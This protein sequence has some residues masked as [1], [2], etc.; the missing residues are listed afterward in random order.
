MKS[1]AFSNG[2]TFLY[3]VIW[4]LFLICLF[5][6]PLHAQMVLEKEAVSVL[7]L[8]VSFSPDDDVS[9]TGNGTFLAE[10]ELDQCGDYV[11]DPPPHNKAYFDAHLRA[12][13]NY[14]RSVSRGKFGI[15]LDSSVIL[16]EEASSS[17]VLNETMSS[18]YPYDDD[19]AQQQGLARLFEKSLE[20]SYAED[21]LNFDEFDIIIVFHA[22]IGQDFSLPFID[23]TQTDIPSTYIDSQFLE[24]QLGSGSITFPNGSAVSSGIILPETQNHLLY[25]ISSEIFAGLSQPCDYQFGLTGTFVLMFGFAVGLPPLWDLETGESG[26]GI[27]ALMDQGSNNG[28]GLVP[29][30]PDPWTRVWAGW[31]SAQVVTPTQTVTVV[32]RD[33]LV[34]EIVRINISTNEYFLIENRNNW[35]RENVD[36][37]SLR[38]AIGGLGISVRGYVEVLLDSANLQRDSTTGVVTSVP[39]YDLGLPGSGLL[40]WHIDEERITEGFASQ[41]VNGNRDRRGIDLEE[42]DG[43]QDMGYP[44]AFLFTDPSAGLWSDMWFDG[45]SQYTIANPAFVNQSPSFGPDTYPSTRSNSGADSY[46]EIN[47]ITKAGK[48]MTFTLANSLLADGFPD[49]SLQMEFLYDFDGDG[50]REIIGMSDSLWWSGPGEIKPEGITLRPVGDYRLAITNSGPAPEL[51]L[52]FERDGLLAVEIKS[53]SST[54][55]GFESVW[56]ASLQLALPSRVVGYTNASK[57][58]L[59]YDDHI[60]IITPDSSWEEVTNEGLTVSWWTRG[61]LSDVGSVVHTSGE[62]LVSMTN[63]ITYTGFEEVGFVYLGV[64]DLDGDAE[65]EIIATDTEGTVYA[66][67]RNLTLLSGFPMELGAAGPFLAGQITGDDHPEIVTKTSQGDVLIIDWTGRISF[68]L[69]GDETSEL[70]MIANYQGR[71]A[72]LTSSEVWLFDEAAADEGNSWPSEH[73]GLLNGRFFSGSLSES[74]V[75]ANNGILDKKRT[76]CY[77]NPADDGSTTLRVTVGEVDNITITVYDLAGFFVERL[78]IANVHSN[79]VNEVVWDVS[80]VESG[81]YLANVEATL[82]GKSASKI[83]KIAVIN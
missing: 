80:Q 21:V 11:I 17:Y 55:S 14:Y 30:P 41:T 3:K 9:S 72:I 36:I 37:D 58:G 54:I 42:A 38:W 5:V 50:Q 22:G 10:P 27:F 56:S 19:Q 60:V 23:P 67:N 35:V 68:H 26:V 13:D 2:G 52:T 47:D 78:K 82:A 4:R 71:N 83:L 8:R 15:D 51:V 79:E 59:F 74:P 43:A 24:E 7:G 73:G 6:I 45:N 33:T 46:L 81:V 48:V 64:V 44:S 40:I 75:S 12:V 18:Y 29:S 70:K 57:V 69:A 76:Y 61:P 31:E 62:G 34:D 1:P 66:L 49:S 16:P 39:N 28:R 32:A 77:P 65:L 53:Y 63:G 25:S 20:A